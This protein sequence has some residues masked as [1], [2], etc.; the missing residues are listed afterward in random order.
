MVA[1]GSRE[2]AGT[3][4]GW[5]LDGDTELRKAQPGHA[6]SPAVHHGAQ[7]QRGHSLSSAIPFSP[8]LAARVPKPGQ[9]A[10]PAGAHERLLPGQCSLPV[11]AAESCV[12]SLGTAGAGDEPWKLILGGNNSRSTGGTSRMRQKSLTR[13]RLTLHEPQPDLQVIPQRIQAWSLGYTGKWL[14]VD[15]KIRPSSSCFKERHSKRYLR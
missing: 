11:Q 8:S 9:A 14:K 12:P 7:E 13:T 4:G 5:W 6:P 1:S 3:Q 15:S 2:E 10:G